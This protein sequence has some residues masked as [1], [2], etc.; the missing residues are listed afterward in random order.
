M[1]VAPAALPMPRA[2]CPALR[3]IATTKYQRLVVR[4]SSMR[5]RTSSVPRCRAVWKPKVG[6]LPGS[7]MSLSIVLGT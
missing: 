4:E 2:R 7:G 1:N 3:P 6:M 5:L